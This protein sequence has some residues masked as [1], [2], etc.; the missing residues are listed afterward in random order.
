MFVLEFNQRLSAR[1]ISIWFSSG[2]KFRKFAKC[3]ISVT[4]VVA[5][6]TKP[7]VIAPTFERGNIGC[8]ILFPLMTKLCHHDNI[9]V[10]EDK[11]KESKIFLIFQHMS[12]TLQ[13]RIIE[14]I[15]LR[16]LPIC[17]LFNLTKAS[18]QSLVARTK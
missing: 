14:I 15:P 8:D 7:K 3:K 16:I 13:C 10:K 5:A 18:V 11:C 17:A 6:R 12:I 1:S 4:E 2:S 9:R